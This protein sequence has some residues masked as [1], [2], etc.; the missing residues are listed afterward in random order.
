MILNLFQQVER[1]WINNY[2]Y[3]ST[4]YNELY[5]KLKSLYL[6]VYGT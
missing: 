2:N 5:R 3:M 1:C 4:N 6:Q